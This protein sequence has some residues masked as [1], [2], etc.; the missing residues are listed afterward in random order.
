MMRAFSINKRKRRSGRGRIDTTSAASAEQK[1]QNEQVAGR[2]WAGGRCV[3]VPGR[4]VA[5]M[6]RGLQP[7]KTAGAS[8]GK[9]SEVSVNLE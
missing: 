2:R 3:R 1:E 4:N 8:K 5:D 7:S 9:K 6:R